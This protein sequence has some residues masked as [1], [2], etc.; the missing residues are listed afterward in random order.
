[1]RAATTNSAGFLGFRLRACN[2]EHR[3]GARSC[4][5][6][7]LDCR[8]TTPLA[9]AGNFEVLPNGLR[10]ESVGMRLRRW[11]LQLCLPNFL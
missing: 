7:G 4:R 3:E 5:A 6:G 2:G 11:R 10:R 8:D 1:M 9:E